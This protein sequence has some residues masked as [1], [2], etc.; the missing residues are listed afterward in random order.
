MAGPVAR[1][2]TVDGATSTAGL[3]RIRFAFQ[4]LSHV[5]T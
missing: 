3:L 4:A 2:R 5:R 1:P